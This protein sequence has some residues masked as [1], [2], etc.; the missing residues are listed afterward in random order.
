M[1]SI[2]AVIHVRGMQY[3]CCVWRVLFSCP[4]HTQ[5]IIYTISA[6]EPL[7]PL[8]VG[9]Q[10]SVRLLFQLLSFSIY[11]I[12]MNMTNDT[13]QLQLCIFPSEFIYIQNTTQLHPI[14][15]LNFAL[16]LNFIPI[17][18]HRAKLYI[19]YMTLN[20]TKNRK[21]QNHFLRQFD[22]LK[23]AKQKNAVGRFSR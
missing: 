6:M 5:I 22:T 4:T 1:S 13:K 8:E 9:D 16:Q 17:S 18:L 7:E 11:L 15:N 14:E 19:I 10:C 20:S 12:D 2:R 3:L 23:M 21:I